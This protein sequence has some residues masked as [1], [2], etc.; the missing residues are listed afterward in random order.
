MKR[1]HVKHGMKKALAL[2]LA[3]AMVVPCAV[4]TGSISVTAAE[5]AK[6]PAKS[7]TLER[8]FAGDGLRQAKFGHIIGMIEAVYPDNSPYKGQKIFRMSDGRSTDEYEIVETVLV[9]GSF[10]S[11]R[12]EGH[13]GYLQADVPPEITGE[14][15]KQYLPD[16]STTD[17]TWSQFGYVYNQPTTAYDKD[18]G[19]VL[20]LRDTLEN[21]SYPTYATE[22]DYEKGTWETKM[23]V[24]VKDPLGQYQE[25]D[26][27]NS[28]VVFDNP[29]AAS[30]D[31][32][33]GITFAAWIKNTSPYKEPVVYG[34]LGDLD[35]NGKIQSQDAL[36]I[37]A[38]AA[39]VELISET[40]L[41]YAN[42]NGDTKSNGEPKIDANDALEILMFV[43][44]AITEFS[45]AASAP[46]SGE[47]ET[48]TYLE[49]SEFFHV[50]MRK[51]EGSDDRKI[52]NRQYLYFSGNGVTYVGDFN[53]PESACTWTLPED[54]KGD[55]ELDLLSSMNGSKWNYVSYTFDGTDFRMYINGNDVGLVRNGHSNYKNDNN[56]IMK[57]VCNSDAQT[58]L[59]G[60][61]GGVKDNFNTYAINT[62]EKYYMDDI[63]IYTCGLSKDEVKQVYED[64]ADAVETEQNRE[65]K[66]LK[67]YSFEGS[68]LKEDE[69]AA[70]T[71]AKFS[72]KRLPSLNEEGKRGKGIKLNAGT[73]NSTGG[74]QLLEN[75][76][77]NRT[78]LTGVSISYWMKSKESTRGGVT[79]ASDG[80]VFSF[81]D[82]E[83]ECTHEKVTSDSYLGP[84]AWAR[85][86]LYF[87]QSFF[88]V[89]CEGATKAVGGSSLKN[90]FTYAPYNYG[91]PQGLENWK[92]QFERYY[93]S[94]VEWKNTLGKDWNFVTVTINNS[95]FV[96]YING[97][98]KVNR[99]IDFAGERFCDF[100]LGRTT[101]ITPKATNNAG[102]RS[103]M[104]FITADDTEAYLGFSFEQGSSEKFNAVG[105]C[106]LDEL[107]F[108][109]K[110]MSAAE[111]KALYND[112]KDEI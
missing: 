97:E 91:D 15:R 82:D 99:C 37:L 111:V 106:W 107:T 64:A 26:I 43:A 13:K 87:K 40:G 20:W 4:A 77:K 2:S 47:S 63:D 108:Y 27:N 67:T 25:F 9:Q 73:Q 70:V 68:T 96:M 48:V 19:M 41:P 1:F 110:D 78:D 6:E 39:G 32:V 79:T 72:D 58:Y 5:P 109:D 16:V 34:K 10:D 80:V 71:H 100:Y 29:F 14:D 98:E 88:G 12:K 8:G 112:A 84:N 75:P 60:R 51:T 49:D 31:P 46:G 103:L 56:E 81:I 89:F 62:S 59:G 61:G 94:Y 35:G 86:Q 54:S 44:G 38:H 24:I 102:A 92:K 23:D 21:Q 30:T 74:V 3:M 65:A 104:D 33:T 76:F 66:V 17:G 18:K 85:S 11:N 7:F 93:E 36:K 53:D 45:G 55:P 90:M 69:L 50:E 105:E 83:H 42:V 22:V 95:G 101:E 28:A 57:F 52:T